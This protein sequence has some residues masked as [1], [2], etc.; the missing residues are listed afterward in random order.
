MTAAAGAGGSRIPTVIGPIEGTRPP[1]GVPR[2]DVSERGYVVEEYQLEGS[3][4]AYVL[5]PDSRATNDGRW[6]V[7]EW[8]EGDYR[9]RILVIRP[10]RVDDFN[11]TVVLNWQNVSAGFESGSPSTGEVY[12]GCAWVAVS[13]QE[14]GIYGMPM[15]AS[16][17]GISG[18]ALVDHDPERYGSLVHP[19]EQACFDIYTQAARAVGPRREPSTDPLGGLPVER[20]VASGTSQ[21]AM[22]LAAYINAIH[23]RA[24][25]LDGFILALWEGRAPRPEEGPISM[26]LRTA[27]RTD[28]DA[29]I[30]VVNSEFESSNLAAL[31]VVDTELLRVWE[32]TGAPHAPTPNRGDQPSSSGWVGNSLDFRPTYEAGLRAMHRWLVDGIPAPAQPRIEFDH[33]HSPPAIRRDEHGNARG[34]IRLPEVAVPTREYRGM[35]FGTGRAP[36]FGAS[37]PLPD[38]VL[39][40]LY[41]TRAVYEARWHAAVDALAATG[42]LR[43]EDAPA[44]HARVDEV[45]LPVS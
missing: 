43:P 42:A 10:A 35:S 37:R 33:A 12:E 18:R 36:L 30:L 11:G 2:S 3:A 5:A 4:I 38:D 21:S 20:V 19:G 29:P 14:I 45:Q 16:R 17:S 23:P 22:R 25:V 39:R 7:E 8:Q 31:G 34:G 24:G 15:G 41:P 26:G 1:F 13:A 6:D 44:M 32:V 28:L 27:L 9:T 40:E